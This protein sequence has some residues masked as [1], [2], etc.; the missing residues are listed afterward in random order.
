MTI[1]FLEINHHISSEKRDEHLCD[2]G[3]FFVYNIC[4]S[5]CLKFNCGNNGKCNI[6]KHGWP[7][8][9]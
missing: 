5:G 1:Y 7:M 3:Y 6:D 4:L 8:C 2:N 9:Q